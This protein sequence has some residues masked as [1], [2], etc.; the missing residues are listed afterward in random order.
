MKK[1]EMLARIERL[2]A[3]VHCEDLAGCNLTHQSIGEI[4][5]ALDELTE[6]YISTYC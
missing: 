5:Q 4:R 6:E 1:L 2:S 3:V